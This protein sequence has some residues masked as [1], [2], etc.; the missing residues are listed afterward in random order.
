[1]AARAIEEELTRHAALTGRAAEI[2]EAATELAGHPDEAM[3]PAC[4]P[5]PRPSRSP[6][7]GRSRTT[8]SDD[9]SEHLE[10]ASVVAGAAEASGHA[11]PR[12]H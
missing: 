7:P 10:F 1:M 8:D 6:T 3:T 12:K 4:A 5:P 2:R 11:E 9:G